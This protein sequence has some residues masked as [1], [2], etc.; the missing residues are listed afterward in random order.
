MF[1]LIMK[2][3]LLQEEDAKKTFR[4]IVAAISTATT[5]TL[6]ILIFKP[7]NML[8]DSERNIKFTDLAPFCHGT[9][10]PSASCHQSS[11]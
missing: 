10:G 3:G 7:F 2:D 8:I 1:D 11:S 5:L 6:S 4:Q 9:V